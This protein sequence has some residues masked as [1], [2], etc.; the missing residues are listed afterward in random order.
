MATTV[1]CYIHFSGCQF[2]KYSNKCYKNDLVI[3]HNTE[4]PYCVARASETKILKEE[5]FTYTAKNYGST[6]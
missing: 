2:W 1:N 3:L 5:L 4:H 6:F